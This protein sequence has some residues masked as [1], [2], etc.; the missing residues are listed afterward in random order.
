MQDALRL[1]RLSAM[2]LACLYLCMAP[3][4]FG[5]LNGDEW[6]HKMYSIV[7]ATHPH[8]PLT[9]SDHCICH[10]FRGDAAATFKSGH[11]LCNGARRPEAMLVC[12]VHLCGSISSDQQSSKTQGRTDIAHPKDPPLS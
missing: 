10:Q 3:I 7:Q 11:L 2:V 8:E 1:A 9:A 6:L 12:K 5:F 4:Y